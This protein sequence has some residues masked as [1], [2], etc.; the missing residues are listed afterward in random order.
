MGLLLPILLRVWAQQ[1]NVPS[2]SPNAVLRQHR[3]NRRLRLRGADSSAS[4]KQFCP[5]ACG[6]ARW[7]A[8]V[9]RAGE[10]ALGF[11]QPRKTCPA[12]RQRRYNIRKTC[13]TISCSTST[14]ERLGLRSASLWHMR[15]HRDQRAELHCYTGVA[16]EAALTAVYMCIHDIGMPRACH[17]S[18][19]IAV[20]A[21]TDDR[22]R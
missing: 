2:L 19:R 12:L 7:L 4:P 13:T 22:G 1:G 18:Y 9:L 20:R 15:S 17:S 16:S 14:S 10:A 8:P 21:A 5:P 11:A 6:R 3:P